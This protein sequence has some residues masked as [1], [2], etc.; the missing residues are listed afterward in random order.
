MT[1]LGGVS[2]FSPPDS[3]AMNGV[4]E[5]K[6]RTVK[7]AAIANLHHAGQPKDLWNFAMAHA[8]SA[9]NVVP[10]SANDFLTPFTA[11]WGTT[12]DVSHMRR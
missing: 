3:Q 8:V 4:C 10:T 6:V 1:S 7:E 2:Q 5:R 9:I 11:L 12:P